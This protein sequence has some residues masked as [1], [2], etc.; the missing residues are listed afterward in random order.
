M[1]SPLS[2]SPPPSWEPLRSQLSAHGQLHLLSPLPPAEA[3]GAYAAQLEQ[4]NLSLLQKLFHASTSLAPA[5][6][7]VTP[8]EGVTRLD[9]LADAGA[10]ERREGLSLIAQGKVAALLLAGGSGTRLGFDAPKGCFNIGMP[11][12]K[13]LFQY[14]AEKVRV[15]QV[16]RRP[17]HIPPRPRG[18]TPPAAGACGAP[19]RRRA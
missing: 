7:S 1:M 5:S 8:F 19:T 11:S 17:T 15:A 10:A 16:W 2:S 12:G 13:S 9:E 18:H 4:L 3:A 14:H 6:G